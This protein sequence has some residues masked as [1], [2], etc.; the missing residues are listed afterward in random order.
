MAQRADFPVVVGIDG[1]PEGVL[2]L[3]WAAYEARLTGRE[4][5]LVHVHDRPLVAADPILEAAVACVHAREPDV[6]VARIS[7]VGTPVEVL[8]AAAADAALVVVGSGHGG[9]FARFGLG[10]VSTAMATRAR[11]PVVVVRP[12]EQ[13]VVSDAPVAVG[14][15][16]AETMWPA[17][18]FAFDVAARHRRPLRVVRCCQP[19]HSSGAVDWTIR[20]AT[21][22]GAAAALSAE[23]PDLPVEFGLSTGPVAQT[24]LSESAR[25]HLLVVGTRGLGVAAGRVLGSVSRAMLA[26]AQCPVAVV[27]HPAPSADGG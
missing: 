4:L 20:R 6:A 26:G 19:E 21:L 18:G 12:G 22:R 17:L 7:S 8:L 27:P 14:V 2:A 16:G 3:R 15:G 5:M 23:Y 9:Q 10:S 25:A 24:L 11:C 1:R 13:Q